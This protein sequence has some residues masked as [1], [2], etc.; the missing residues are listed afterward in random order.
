MV[1]GRGTRDDRCKMARRLRGWLLGS[2]VRA[3]V[4]ERER[5]GDGEMRV[6]DAYAYAMRV[7]EDRGPRTGDGAEY[8]Y[9]EENNQEE[10]RASW[11]QSEQDT[12]TN[13]TCTTKRTQ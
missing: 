11:R 4:M 9:S 1:G 2:Y 6:Q 8:K 13:E 10:E 7:R 5:D 3:C 12:Q